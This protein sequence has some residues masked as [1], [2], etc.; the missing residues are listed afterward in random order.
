MKQLQAD[1]TAFRRQARVLKALANESRLRIVERLGRGEC[2]AGDLTQLV[3]LDQTTVSKHLAVLRAQ[4]IVEDR[5]E[6]NA[7]IYRLLTPCVL[8]FLSCSLQ[9][10]EERR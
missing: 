8:T 5:R 2:S 9:V 1:Q 4:G 6:G 3:G 7:V 10:L